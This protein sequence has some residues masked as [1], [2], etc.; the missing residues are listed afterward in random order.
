MTTLVFVVVVVPTAHGREGVDD[1]VPIEAV[2]RGVTDAQ[3]VPVPGA[4]VTATE[5]GTGAA[6]SA[7]TV[8]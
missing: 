2:V 1:P 7:V 5:V 3:G 4:A 8:E 6:R